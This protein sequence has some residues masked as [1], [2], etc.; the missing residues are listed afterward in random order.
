MNT[1]RQYVCIDLKSFYA[2]VECMARGFDSLDT[3]L[4]VADE[5]RTE[6]TICLAVSP[7]LK[8]YGIPGRARLF[9]VIEKVRLANLERKRRIG[10][11]PFTGSSCSAKELEK[12]PYLE[13]DFHIATPR[14]AVYMEA[15]SR[16]Y[17]IYMHY[18]SPEDMH[19]YSIDEVFMDVTPYLE[20]YQMTA[21]Q[22]AQK[23]IGLITKELGITATGGV[24]TNLYLAKVAMDVL[25][26]HM[27]PNEDGIR[28]AELDE[29]SYRKLFW[30]HTP[31][32][33]FWR[34]GRGIRDRLAKHGMYT[35]GDIARCSV[36]ADD[37]YYNEKLLY[38]IFGKNAELLIDHAWG[39]ENCTI[40]QIKSYVPENNSLSTGQVLSEPYDSKKARLIVHE[41][42]DLLVLDLV[43]KHLVTDQIVLDI[44]FDRENMTEGFL[45]ESYKGPVE[46]DRY[47]RKVPKSIHGST[48]LD[49]HHSSSR[50]IIEATLELYDRIM[51]MQLYVRGIAVT[52]SHVLPEDKA[53][54]LKAG[55][56]ETYE[57]LDLFS[58]YRAEEEKRE[59]KDRERKKERQI[60]DAVLSIQKRYG[61]NAILKGMNFEEGATTRER[62]AQIG[63]HKA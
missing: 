23:L 12:N 19:V 51:P 24:G 18:I 44:R 58:D 61:K 41:M 39:F 17:D 42:T 32:T 52:A 47:G 38:K 10:G 11:K 46:I 50:E 13:L 21:K 6:K 4:V 15:S 30:C 14:M 8:A 54:A 60:Q 20:T 45:A 26:K 53:G 1:T 34:I 5:S 48:N 49:G 59:Q 63:G 16:I 43:S 56:Q 31:I 37:E 25:A 29:V 28:I 27:E 35:L 57:Q 2:S 9:E 22:L 62:N 36:G 7:S 3:N 55:S 40:E 33:D